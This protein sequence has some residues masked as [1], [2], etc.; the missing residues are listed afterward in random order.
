M[1]DD[2]HG[3]G[4]P[5]GGSRWDP[6]PQGEYDDGATAFVELPEGASTPCWPP[7]ALAAPGH[8]Y[9]PPQ[10]TVDP[11]T[12]GRHRPGR[13]GRVADARRARR[14]RPVERS[15]RPARPVRGAPAA[16]PRGR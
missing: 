9:V 2:Q 5:Q 1:T 15:A 12:T 7:T 14:R 6:L 8:G 3:Q 13:H 11:A 10:I 4:T 16:G